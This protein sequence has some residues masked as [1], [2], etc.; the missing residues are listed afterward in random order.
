MS[1]IDLRKPLGEAHGATPV[2]YRRRAVRF[3]HALL[4]E[5]KKRETQKRTAPYYDDKER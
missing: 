3:T 4:W 2:P 1:G 5:T